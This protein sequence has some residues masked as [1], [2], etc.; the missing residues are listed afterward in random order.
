[1]DDTGGGYRAQ[2]IDYAADWDGAYHL[3]G[4]TQSWVNGTQLAATSYQYA[5]AGTANGQPLWR[6]TSNALSN[7]TNQTIIRQAIIY[8]GVGVSSIYRNQPYSATAANGSKQCFA[9]EPGDFDSTGSFV[10]DAAGNALRTTVVTGTASG[11]TTSLSG[12]NATIDTI[13][14]VD[15][16]STRDVTIRDERGFAV[17]AEGYVYSGGSWTLLTWANMT[18]NDAGDLLSR[19]TSSGAT[20]EAEY[21]N[22]NGGSTNYSSIVFSNSGLIP[23]VVNNMTKTKAASSPNII[24]IR[25]AAFMRHCNFQFPPLTVSHVLCRQ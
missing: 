23:P 20:Y 18:Y 10:Y 19:Q 3:P 16:V 5:V 7:A 22:V 9:Y 24:T 12:C 11:S 13:G 21:T 17:R 6:V 15:S 14:L 4:S 25:L 2:V 1:M 8:Q